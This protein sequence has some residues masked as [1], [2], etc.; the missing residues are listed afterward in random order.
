MAGGYY[1]T[2]LARSY[3]L[4]TAATI[5]TLTAIPP[6]RTSARFLDRPAHAQEEEGPARRRRRVADPSAEPQPQLLDVMTSV[7]RL[8]DR[9][10]SIKDQLAWIGEVLLE[11]A[12]Q[13]G[14][15]PD[16]S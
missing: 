12:S 4:L 7:R 15:H 9:V 10:A 8:E 2:R 5:A 13:Q 11:T 14:R 3:G 6:V 1:I 16:H